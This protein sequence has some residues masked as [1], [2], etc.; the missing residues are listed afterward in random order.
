MARVPNPYRPGF[1]QAPAAL[2]GRDAVLD[3]VRDALDVAALDHRTPRPIVLVGGRGVGKTVLLG[4]AAAIAAADRSWLTV[5]IEMRPRRPFTPVLVQRLVTAR[6]LYRHVESGGRLEVTAAKVRATVLGVGAEVEVTRRQPREDPTLDL[7]SALADACAAAAERQA[8]LVLTLDEA[9]SA[10]RGELADFAATLQQ[11]VPDRWPL[12][13]LL[14]G[15]PSIRDANRGVTYLE[16]GAWH[17]LGLLDEDATL[18]GL[19]EPARMAGRPMTAT[20]CER[21]AA[22]SGGYP[23]AIQLL[24]HHAW[25]ASHGCD[26]IHEGHVAAAVAAADRELRAGLF[27]SRWYDA[28]PKERLYLQSM[29]VLVG[30]GRAATSAAVAE[31][32]GK[33]AGEVS[34]LR[35]RL[36]RKGTIFPAPGALRFA[37]PGMAA[38]VSQVHGPPEQ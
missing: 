23:Y 9:Q 11:H 20:A 19:R 15:L 28:S 37:V 29:A 18:A 6:D 26:E 14:A 1:N 24:G 30:Q 21:L 4:E 25:L 38:W 35:E 5:P 32:L 7:E 3:S 17:A 8:G 31:V 33:R 27:E 36:M 13:V 22:A 10:E 34:Y 16:R 2:V 12:V